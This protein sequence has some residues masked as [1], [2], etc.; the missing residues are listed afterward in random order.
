MRAR[1]SENAFAFLHIFAHVH[2]L[3]VQPHKI[4][5]DGLHSHDLI[6]DFPVCRFDIRDGSRG[7]IEIDQSRTFPPFVR[8][9][10]LANG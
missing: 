8:P 9:A 6:F 7:L 3:V 2:L 1:V 10:E 5:S 4:R